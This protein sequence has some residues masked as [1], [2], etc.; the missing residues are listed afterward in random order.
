MGYWHSS[1][2]LVG[3]AKRFVGAALQGQVSTWPC[4]SDLAS[5][6]GRRI[7][8]IGATRDDVSVG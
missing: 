2:R 3:G 4:Q 5:G 1:K 7:K 6:G 8:M